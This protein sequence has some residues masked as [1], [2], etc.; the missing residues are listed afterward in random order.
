ME[1]FLQAVGSRRDFDHPRWLAVLTPHAAAQTT[2]AIRGQ[3]MDVAGSPGPILPFK[4]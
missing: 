1:D 4:P 2:D 3:I